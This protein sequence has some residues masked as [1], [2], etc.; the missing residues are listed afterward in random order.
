MNEVIVTF[1]DGNSETFKGP[2]VNFGPI[3]GFI[4]VRIDEYETI[5]FNVDEIFSVKMTRGQVETA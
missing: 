2:E 4:A 3:D 5:M 1:T